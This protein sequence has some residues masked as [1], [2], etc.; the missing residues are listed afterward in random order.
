VTDVS[1]VRA[2][3]IIRDHPSETSVDNYFTRQYIPDDSSELLC[4][5]SAYIVSHVSA[6]QQ[7]SISYVPLPTQS[8][9][10]TLCGICGSYD[11]DFDIK[12]TAFWV[13]VPCGLEVKRRFRG[14][15]CLHHQGDTLY[16]RMLSS[17][18][19][20]VDFSLQGSYAV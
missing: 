4:A 11:E 14:A 5:F 7:K 2:A 20:Y 8:Q 15:Y 9:T 17:E 19:L 18:I 10:S 1:E 6:T 13:I 16:P 3:S 12:M